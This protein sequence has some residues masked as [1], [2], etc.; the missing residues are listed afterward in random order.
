M[1]L[2]SDLLLFNTLFN[3]SSSDDDFHNDGDLEI[4]IEE[5][6]LEIE[7][8]DGDTIDDIIR[9]VNQKLDQD[10]VDYDD[11]IIEISECETDDEALNFGRS[12]KQH[13]EKVLQDPSQFETK[14]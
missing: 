11:A 13:F 9:K 14:E 7:V 10:G 6:E 5:S 3:N 4:E 8:E 2:L 12:E 1:G